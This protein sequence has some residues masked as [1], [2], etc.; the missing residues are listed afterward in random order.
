MNARCRRGWFGVLA[1]VL[2]GLHAWMAA[3]VTRTFST[4]VD[5]VVH[6]TSGYAYWTSQDFRLQPENGNFP[7]RWA[8]IPLLGEDIRFP[9]KSGSSWKTADTWRLGHDFFYNQDNDLPSM[10]AAGRAMIAVLSALLCLVVYLWSRDLFGSRA[11]W[12]ALILAVFSPTLLAHGGLITSDTAAALGFSVAVLS[13][14]R[15]LHRPSIGRF[16]VA[17]LCVGLL[18]I[19]K[20]SVV[21]FAPISVLLATIRLTRARP[22]RIR[23]RHLEIVL[24]GWKR[25]PATL[26]LLI[27]TASICALVIWAAYGFRYNAAPASAADDAGFNR[28]WSG[29]LLEI[30]PS[31][32]RMILADGSSV[33]T[34]EI[35]HAPGPLQHIIRWTRD[36]RLLP[37]AWLYGLA[38]VEI[39]ARGRL[40]YFAGEYSMTGWRSFFPTAFAV[41]TTL[42]AL[43]LMVLGGIT[44][45]TAGRHK[46]VWI[47][48]LSPLLVLL[49][50]YWAFS[51]QS[52]LNIGHRHLLPIYPALF[53]LASGSALLIPNRKAGAVLIIALL[54][55]HGRES[56]AT[57]PDYLA[58]FNPIAGGPQ[59]AHRL[60]VDSSLDWG[61]DL[62]RLR[63]WL[64]RNAQ[65]EKVF[66]S[67]FG[68]GSPKHE[69][70]DQAV[71]IG[72]GYFDWYSR[73]TPP[74]L[75]GGTYCI[76]ATMFRRV[77]THVRG[78]WS[79]SYENTYQRMLK[80][81]RHVNSRAAGAPITDLDGTL[82]TP[83]VVKDK[84]MIGEHLMFGRLCHFLQLREP[85]ARAGHS[86]LIYRL[87]DNEVALALTAPLP[88]LNARLMELQNKQ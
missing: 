15:L 43:G 46:R 57:R 49:A 59:Q 72:D 44:L 16:V 48:R 51:I 29:V 50:V 68:S 25:I 69:G 65:G 36:H 32:T 47:Y 67:Y 31:T 63:E 35:N 40:A 3:S 86:F 22:F 24:T 88:V 79:A 11:G 21:L 85:D 39:N 73:P 12:I 56:V 76:S 41:K 87:S 19:S 75:S 18:A 20:Y 54:A 61:Q 52:R 74:P 78:P 81:L 77:Y 7:Q 8:A 70:I 58:Y 45:L 53:V 84:L 82:L 4:T 62:P 14:W 30:P 55:W 34:G 1:L 23:L 38:F 9:E 10:L 13:W 27:G 33:D 28:P 6:L 80:W 5:E 26:M 83:D 66:L 60:F 2:C 17:G 71:R 64:E 37:E 42:P